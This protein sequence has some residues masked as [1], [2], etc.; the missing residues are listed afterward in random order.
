M[1]VTPQCDTFNSLII[2]A[3][4]FVQSDPAVAFCGGNFVVVWSDARF[5]GGFYWLAALAVDTAGN[6]VDTSLCI[7]AQQYLDENCPDIASDGTRC[8]A[9]WH[10][11]G[12]PF[13][14]Y[15]RFLD[16]AGMPIDTVM[17]LAATLAGSN[18]DPCVTYAAGRYLLVWA[19]KRSGYSDLDIYGQ[20]LSSTGSATGP[21]VTI[22]TGPENQMH[23]AVCSDGTQ[24]LVIWRDGTTCISGQWLDPNTGPVGGIFQISNNTPFYRFRPGVDASGSEF[25][26]AWSEVRNDER[27]I[28]GSVEPGMY[29]EN[30]PLNIPDL[31]N[32]ASVIRGQLPSFTGQQVRIYDI[33]GRTV[34]GRRVPPGV[35]YVRIG[36][37]VLHKIV[38]IE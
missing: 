36:P 26:A 12:E 10:T 8:L 38:K 30:W 18:L 4:E 11:G 16:Q 21:M 34:T 1:R 37:N 27:D 33:C 35:Y 14:I 23:P 24:F 29:I 7:G 2:H 13:G 6:V 3:D 22:A 19:D 28:F 5:T 9:V 17:N 32:T 31:R 25:L 20:F 15:G